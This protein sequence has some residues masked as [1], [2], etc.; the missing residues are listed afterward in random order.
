MSERKINENLRF[1]GKVKNIQSQNGTFQKI[2]ID[3]PNPVNQDGSANDY[4]QGTFLW[5][6]KKT[7]KKFIVKQLGFTKVSQQAAANGF[8]LSVTINLG[9]EYDVNEAK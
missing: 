1:V 5:L 2:L 9:N 8:T 7:K 4:Y 3:N 6:D